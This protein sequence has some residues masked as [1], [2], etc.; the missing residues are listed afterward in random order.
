MQTEKAKSSHFDRTRGFKNQ[1]FPTMV[2]SLIHTVIIIKLE[3]CK[4]TFRNEFTPVFS[5]F[6]VRHWNPLNSLVS[7]AILLIEL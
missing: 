6:A 2:S 3:K 5:Y 4:R 7:S 1:I